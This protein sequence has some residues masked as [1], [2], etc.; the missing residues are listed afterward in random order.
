MKA[1]VP[2]CAVL[3]RRHAAGFT[4]IELLLAIGLLALMS[5]LAWRGVDGMGQARARLQQ[6]ADEVQ[7]LQATLGQW[8][9][10]LDALVEQPNWNSLQWDGRSLRLLRR[11]ALADGA[12]LQVVAWARRGVG[13]EGQWWRWVSPA[14]TTRAELAQAWQ[15][16][17]AWAQ[18]ERQ[19]ESP[20]ALATVP[21]DDWQIFFYRGNAWSNPLSSAG[22]AVAADNAAAPAPA[23]ST[24]QSAT[25]PEG[26]RLLL[27]LPEGH[28]VSGLLTRDW[29]RPVLGAAS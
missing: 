14:L 3:G 21:L 11:S 19:T 6:H 10:D 7:T 28:S 4:L 26:V 13:T 8:A 24:A 15:Q 2:W 12:G 5:V 23:Q 22:A 9:A 17:Q 20:Q 16:A 25:L 1:H 29:V 27:K 18:V